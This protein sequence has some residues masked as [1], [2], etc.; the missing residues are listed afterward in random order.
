[1]GERSG[2]FRISVELPDGKRPL[3][4]TRPRWED[5]TVLDLQNVERREWTGMIWLRIE[6]G[7]G[8]L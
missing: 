8:F 7:G 6:T 2:I 1:M 4:R 3:G 5:N